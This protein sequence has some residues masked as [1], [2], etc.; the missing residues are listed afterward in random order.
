MGK[1]ISGKMMGAG[2]GGIGQTCAPI[3]KLNKNDENF[4]RVK[5]RQSLS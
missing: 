3:I 5:I 1:W 4:F 2:L